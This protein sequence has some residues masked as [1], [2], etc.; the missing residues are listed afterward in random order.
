MRAPPACWP[1]SADWRRRIARR[2]AARKRFDEKRAGGREERDMAA[3]ERRTELLDR[4]KATM[5]MFKQ[6]AAKFG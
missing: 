1:G 4:D 3:R 2:D 6:M 5:D